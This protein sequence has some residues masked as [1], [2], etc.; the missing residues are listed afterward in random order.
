MT[1]TATYTIPGMRVREHLTDVPLDWADPSRGTIQVFA[2]E[3]ADPVRAGDD[4]PCLVY[5]QGGPGGKGPRPLDRSGWLGQALRDHRVVLVDQRGT[6]RS[7]RVDG[8]RMSAFPTAE[9]A[10]DF[11][12]HFRADS[13]VADH[14]HL[15]KTVFGGRRW[16]T[17]GQSYGGFL[18]LTYLS[19]AP[20]GLSAC[21]VT[22]GLPALDPSAAEVYRRTYPRVEA[23]NREFRRRYPHQVAQVGRVADR[24]AAGDVRLPDGD[25][26]TVRRFQSLGLDLGMKPGY[27]RLHW[28]L[29]EAFTGDEVSATFLHDVLARTSYRDNPLFAALQESI[30]GHGAG[31]T[32]W[33]AQAE[34]DR[35]PQF[36]EDARPL[37]FTGEMIYPWMFEE[38][39]ELRPFRG[40]VEVLATREEWPPLY[41][42]DRLA[43][44][45]VPVAAAVYHDDMY[46]DAGLQL[47]TA[48]RVGNVRTWITNE[49]EHDGVREDERVYARLAGMVRELGGGITDAGGPAGPRHEGGSVA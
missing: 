23:K 43:A 40:A 10:A 4:L 5:L 14:E 8:R 39:A 16:S 12:A 24:L 15:R 18:T 6:G 26:L 13:I 48:S 30:Y 32:G 37:L 36:A 42:P 27:E 2:R 33:A 29:D 47:D 7:T 35:R 9:A 3:I 17:L 1:V 44:N 28:L 25:V 45:E 20:E 31:A 11:L 38:I 41:D 21:Y 49:Y 34:R 46:V 22:G 19:T